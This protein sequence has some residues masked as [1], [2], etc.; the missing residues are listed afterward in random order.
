MRFEAGT[1]AD[2]HLRCEELRHTLWTLCEERETEA[3]QRLT[4]IR[5]D[6]WLEQR[7]ASLDSN[8]VFLF[9]LELDRFNA[10]VHLLSDFAAAHSGNPPEGMLVRTLITCSR[11]RPCTSIALRSQ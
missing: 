5:S 11:P 10:S 1:K 3:K 2:L 8:I 7:V 4:A 9:Q 6:G